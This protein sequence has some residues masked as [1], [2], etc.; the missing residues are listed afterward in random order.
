MDEFIKIVIGI[1]CATLGGFLGYFIRLF[2]EHRLALNRI[3]ESIR[4][5]EFNK[6]AAEFKA[7]FVDEMFR[8]GRRMETPHAIYGERLIDI[9]IANEN[10]KLFLRLSCPMIC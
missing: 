9:T 5:A 2:I 10:L 6:A 4:I 3:K 7:V 1:S 8:I